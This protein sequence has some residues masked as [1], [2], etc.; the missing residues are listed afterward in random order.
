MD[1]TPYF[2]L[3]YLV[4]DAGSEERIIAKVKLTPEKNN[5]EDRTFKALFGCCGCDEKECE[6]D[7]CPRGSYTEDCSPVHMIN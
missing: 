1:K 7:S 2:R 4:K 6:Y 3:D 5:L